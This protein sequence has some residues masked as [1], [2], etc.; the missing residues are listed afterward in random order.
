MVLVRPTNLAHRENCIEVDYKARKLYQ[1]DHI[2]YGRG[3]VHTILGYRVSYC[4]S[5]SGATDSPRHDE[6]MRCQG[7]CN[8]GIREHC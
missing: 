4:A 2:D 3:N 1:Y 6:C 7:E 5:H 8:K